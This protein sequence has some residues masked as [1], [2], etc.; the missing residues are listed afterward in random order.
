MRMKKAIIL[1]GLL[2]AMVHTTFAEQR[3]VF[4]QFH[5]KSNPSTN[6]S[7]NRAPTRLPIEVVYDSDTHKIEV[8]GDESMDAEVFLYNANGDLENYSSSLNSEFT[9]LTPGI[10]IIQIQGDGWYAEG[11]IEVE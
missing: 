7:V 3:D 4:I 8:T 6:T 11:E 1:A 9:V 5:R 2:L 10:Y